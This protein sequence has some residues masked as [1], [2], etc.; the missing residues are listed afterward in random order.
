MVGA[1]ND[2][3]NL[4]AAAHLVVVMEKT[5]SS[6]LPTVDWFVNGFLNACILIGALVTVRWTIF[7][8]F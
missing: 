6:T 7:M 1:Q 4:Q 8:H 5:A 3:F 2:D